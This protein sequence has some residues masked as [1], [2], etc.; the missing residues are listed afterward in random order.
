M[1]IR[2]AS[3]ADKETISRLHVASIRGLCANHYTREQ[4]HAWTGVL[5]PSVYDQALQEKVFFVACD[6]QDELLGI[7]ILDVENKEVS[8]VYIRPNA[9][10]KGIGSELLNE[11]EKTARNKNIATI[12]VYST[13]NAKGF[14]AAHGYAKQDLTF[15]TLP[16]GSQLECIRM[17]KDLLQDVK[18]RH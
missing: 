9:A 5:I 4:L 11:L 14:Y 1:K 6:S 3:D 8:A 7:G 17:V 16:N 12:T 10:G 13:L 18:Q 15:H 2:K